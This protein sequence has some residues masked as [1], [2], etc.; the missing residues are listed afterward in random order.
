MEGLNRLLLEEKQKGNITGIQISANYHISHILFV[1]DVLFMCIGT[2]AKWKAYY[3]TGM[4]I[5]LNKSTFYYFSINSDNLSAIQNFIPLQAISLES[6]FEY[7]N[8]FLKPNDYHIEEWKWLIK[9]VEQ[10]INAQNKYM[11][12]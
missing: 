10:K 6:G 3:A 4:E 2:V 12:L 11:V 5:N 8:Y 1:D 7:L 9:K